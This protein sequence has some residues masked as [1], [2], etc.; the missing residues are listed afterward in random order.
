MDGA[1][2][3]SLT[4]YLNRMVCTSKQNTL[5]CEDHQRVLQYLVRFLLEPGQVSSA[6]LRSRAAEYKDAYDGSRCQHN[7]PEK[8]RED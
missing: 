3:A 4:R 6:L 2:L 8:E 5:A 1:I 7:N